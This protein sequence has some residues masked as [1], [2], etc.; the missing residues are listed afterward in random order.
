LK[1]ATK[2]MLNNGIIASASGI[3]QN[4]VERLLPKRDVQNGIS[5]GKY[6]SNKQGTNKKEMNNFGSR[7]MPRGF[8]LIE[9][10]VVIAII[11]ILAAMLLPA[12]AKA[13]QKAQAIKC[14]N[15]LRQ[16]G[17]GFH[18]YCDD[19]RD[20][21]PEEG[22]VGY[23]ITD[24]GAPGA[25]GHSDNLDY[26]WYNCV[27]PTISQPTLVSLYTSKNGPLPGSAT[28][29]SCPSAPAP[30]LNNGFSSPLKLAKAYFM[31]GENNR[32][33]VNFPLVATGT[34]QNK[35]SG[36]VKPSDTVFLGEVDGNTATGT[37]PAL[38]G[39]TGQ[40]AVARHGKVG[41]FA[42]CDGSCRSAHTNEF[43][44]SSSDTTA[45][46]EWNDPKHPAIYWYPSPTS[47]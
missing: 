26:A 39:V 36:V 9:L 13:K 35:L 24:P 25:A 21:V 17:L 27:G 4:V 44:L 31:Y 2:T 46:A 18:M 47:N 8:T 41:N 11:A 38:S 23:P 42:M 7:Q 37:E 33:C 28:I 32:L 1:Q 14:L 12:L 29:F 34:P 40:Y 30:N 16:W 10:L 5:V 6:P 15:N 43:M 20:V 45:S 19:N 22:S 3:R